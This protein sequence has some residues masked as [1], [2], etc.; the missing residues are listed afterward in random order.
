MELRIIAVGSRMPAWVET[1]YLDYARRLGPECGVS[2]QEI[3]S[4]KRLKHLTVEQ[5]KAREKERIVAALPPGALL[6][7]L[8]ERGRQWDSRQ[9]ATRLQ[10]WLQD[11]RPVALVIGGADGLHDELRQRADFIWSLSPLTLPH[12]LV[13][14]VLIEQIYR[15]WSIIKNHPYHRGDT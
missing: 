10:A 1:A 15:A 8:D 3:K 5:V 14:I 6:G 4:E 2:L 13:R 7:V 11:G 9:L 12:A